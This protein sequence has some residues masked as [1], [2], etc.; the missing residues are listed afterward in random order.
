M[1]RIPMKGDPPSLQQIIKK[2]GDPIDA[3]AKAHF[4]CLLQAEHFEAGGETQEAQ[5][6]RIMAEKCRKEMEGYGYVP[7]MIDGVAKAV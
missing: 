2:Y 4:D 3:L 1:A 5:E 7:G 6:V